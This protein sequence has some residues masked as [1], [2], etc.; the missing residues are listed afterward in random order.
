[1]KTATP[2]KTEIALR[3]KLPRRYW[4]EINDLLVSFGQTI[5]RPLS[6]KCSECT[7]EKWCPKIGVGRRR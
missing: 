7:I 1:V 6:P 4:L 3:E 5:C 2:E